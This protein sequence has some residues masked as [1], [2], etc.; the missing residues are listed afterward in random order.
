MAI[1]EGDNEIYCSHTHI[2]RGRKVLSKSSYFRYTHLA[3]RQYL[4]VNITGSAIALHCGK[5][6]VQ[7]QWERAYFDPQWHQDLW[8][9]LLQIWTWRPWLCP[10][11]Y[12]S[13]NFRFNP[14]SGGFSPDRWNIT[15]LWVFCYTVINFFSG[16]APKSSP[17]NGY[18][19]TVFGSYD[20][21]SR[22]DVPSGSSN[23]I[24]IHLGVI[25]P[26]KG[27]E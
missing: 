17:W 20:V 10:W 16:H 1:V 26:K 12:I 25:S 22:K 21:F 18:I 4:P 5:A 3:L 11:V 23:D 19:F 6:H 13:A 24:W 2:A 8:F 9:F 27:R 7:S 15:V 14:F